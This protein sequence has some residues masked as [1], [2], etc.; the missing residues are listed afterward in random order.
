MEAL[1]EAWVNSQRRANERGLSS[2]RTEK[3]PKNAMNMASHESYQP[4][5]SS[6]LSVTL[7]TFFFPFAVSFQRQKRV[8]CSSCWDTETE[9]KD[10]SLITKTDE[11]PDSLAHLIP[12]SCWVLILRDLSFADLHNVMLTSRSLALLT[13]PLISAKLLDIGY[14]LFHLLVSSSSSPDFGPSKILRREEPLSEVQGHSGHGNERDSEQV[15]QTR[16]E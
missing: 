6:L 12:F 7:I 1:L 2:S 16:Q 8:L 5:V 15:T 13:A 14:V 10:P 11:D 3:S 4:P 9:Q